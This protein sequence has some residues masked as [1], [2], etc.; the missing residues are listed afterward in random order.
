MNHLDREMINH[1]IVGLFQSTRHM[2]QQA[3][4]EA[5][6]ERDERLFKDWSEW[7]ELDED[8]KHYVREYLKKR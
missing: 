8:S 3:I 6:Q 7:S 5:Q 4:K 2:Y 1:S